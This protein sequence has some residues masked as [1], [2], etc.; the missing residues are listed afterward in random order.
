[1]SHLD[2]P[3]PEPET[4]PWERD[5]RCELI[6]PYTEHPPCSFPHCGKSTTGKWP[7]PIYFVEVRPIDR[8]TGGLD[9]CVYDIVICN[10]CHTLLGD[11]ATDKYL[12]IEEAEKHRSPA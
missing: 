7:E 6:P 1:M 3:F 11:L 12:E 10:K 5:A 2:E 8:M 9:Q 4:D